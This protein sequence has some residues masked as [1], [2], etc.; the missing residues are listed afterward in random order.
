MFVR[1]SSLGCH[2][3]TE[4][5]WCTGGGLLLLCCCLQGLMFAAQE[6]SSWTISCW[7]VVERLSWPTLVL[8]SNWSRFGSHPP[9]R[10]CCADLHCKKKGKEK[11][12]SV[13]GTPY[14]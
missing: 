3:C 11:R 13:L 9:S 1:K 10:L 12:K 8:Q 5:M 7:G 6:M 14:W 2:T 4:Q